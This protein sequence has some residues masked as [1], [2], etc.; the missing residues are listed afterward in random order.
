MNI[1]GQGASNPEEREAIRGLEPRSVIAAGSERLAGTA[2]TPRPRALWV[3]PSA[4]EPLAEE[5]RGLLDLAAA[6]PAEAAEKLAASRFDLLVL[7][8]ALPADG[9]AALVGSL[10]ELDGP[11]RPAVLLL[12]REGHRGELGRLLTGHA[13]DIVDASW[14]P[15]EL[16]ARARWAL[17]VRGFLAELH[18]KNSELAALYE[19]V[20]VM[21]RR[22]AEE[23]RLASNVQRSLMPAP[24]PHASLDVAREFMPF[25]EI[26]GDYYDLMPIGPSRLVFAIGDVMGKGVPAAL[27]AA[28]LKACL[29]SQLQ[30]GDV[31][32]GELVARV[33][34][35]F[36]EV[37][38]VSPRGLFA[39]LFFGVFDFESGRFDYVNAGH[40]HPFRIAPDGSME[41]L[42]AGG[43]VLGL[44][45]NARFETGTI[46]VQPGDMFV[47][48]SDGVTD[49]GNGRGE[50]YGV[51]RLKTAAN[52]SRRDAPRLALYTLLGEIQGWS[53]G[54][55][56]DDDMTLI[57]AK[58]R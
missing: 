40:D 53:G 10:P 18:R 37:S 3:G 11:E 44:L 55:P 46:A 6:L 20:E 51:E 50:L 49:R 5:L 41:D 9:L 36:S 4:A 24:F 27:L 1:E 45:E 57:V 26:G 13:D 43:T 25:R 29:R 32:P 21:A 16:T 2:G 38:G 39:S 17:R 8:G 7:D 19:R 28:N 35:L 54:A 30:A 14:G 48:Y 58:A 31:A 12:A 34:R 33:N 23:L 15:Q 47:F 42:V 52:R 56:A 22:M